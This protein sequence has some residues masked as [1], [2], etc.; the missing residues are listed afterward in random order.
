MMAAVFSLS[1]SAQSDKFY[2]TSGG[3][4]IFSFADVEYQNNSVP[5]NMRFTLFFHIG[6]FGH[7]DFTNNLGMYSGFGIRNIGFIT[8]ENGVKDKRRT[9]SFGIPLALK[10]GNF[11]KNF[12]LFG[13]GEYELFFHYKH[14]RFIDDTKKKY[15][16]WFSDRTNRFVPSVFGGIQFPGGIN[17]KFKYYLDNFMNSDLGEVDEFGETTDYS[18]FNKTQVFY[19]ALSFNIKPKNIMDFAKPDNKIA[20]YSY[21]G[22]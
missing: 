13:G 16:D 19:I 9:Y 7:Y 14:K 12:Y 17:L 15:K 1:S 18:D 20:R 8:E 5:T 11:D 3:E 22:Y 10:I 2:T 4:I 6:Q 21:S